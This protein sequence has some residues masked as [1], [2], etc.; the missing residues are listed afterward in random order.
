[1]CKK[2]VVAQLADC[3]CMMCPFTHRKQLL[4]ACETFEQLDYEWEIVVTPSNVLDLPTSPDLFLF[5]DLHLQLGSAVRVV[6]VLLEMI[7]CSERE[8]MD[9]LWSLSHSVYFAQ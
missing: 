7:I 8:S 6:R 2:W 5:G 9:N 1:M 4:L 3:V